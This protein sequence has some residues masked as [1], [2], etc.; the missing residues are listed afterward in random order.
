MTHVRNNRL[1]ETIDL[2][3]ASNNDN[4]V[5]EIRALFGDMYKIGDLKD[6][7][8][9]EDIPETKDTIEGNAS[10]KAYY[11]FEKFGINCFSDDTG[12]EIRSLN[13]APGVFSARYAGEQ[14]NDNS[15]MNLVL[16]NMQGVK[17]RHAQFKTVISLIMDGKEKQFT[18]ILEG[19]ILN[20]M[21]GNKGFGYDPIFKPQGSAISLAEMNPSEK[22]AI[23][24]RAIAVKKLVSYLLSLRA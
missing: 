15:N 7:G 24:H 16:K 3:F 4:K 14:K 17:D 1:T 9:M 10:Q 22:N 20:S 19:E 12:L 18:G 21:Q 5:K 2:V 6:I 11:V 8:C 13:G 23:S